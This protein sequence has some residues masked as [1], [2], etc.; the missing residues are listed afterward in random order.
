MIVGLIL[1]AQTD[2]DEDNVNNDD[3]TVTAMWCCNYEYLLFC[4]FRLSYS[5]LTHVPK[6]A[7]VLTDQMHFLLLAQP[8]SAKLS[9]HAV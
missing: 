9:S 2:D 4:L 3:D 5:R 7:A 1:V 6:L 8:T